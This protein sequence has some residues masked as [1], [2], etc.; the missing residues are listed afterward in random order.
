M[1]SDDTLISTAFE[2]F[3]KVAKNFEVDVVHCEKYYHAPNNSA[4]TDKNLLSL[5]SRNKIDVIEIP[6]LDTTSLPERVQKLI[7]NRF[8]WAPWSHFIKREF[9]LDND[10]DFPKLNIADDLIF[11]IF[12]YCSAEKVV[13]MPEAFY[14]WRTLA[15]SNSRADF[16]HIQVEKFIHRRVNDIFLGIQ[17]LDK[18]TKRFELFEKELPYKYALIDFFVVNQTYNMR[19]LYINVMY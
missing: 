15:D 12:L 14:V 8:W 1:D 18:F 5:S 13:T 7:Q 6:T 2:E 9:M 10:I 19:N 11:S 3:Y 4:P 16:T 17:I